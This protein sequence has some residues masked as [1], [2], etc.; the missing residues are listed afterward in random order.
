MR[1]GKAT[2]YTRKANKTTVYVWKK[3]GN[4]SDCKFN[5]VT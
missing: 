4:V 2:I 1:A 3:P 5:C